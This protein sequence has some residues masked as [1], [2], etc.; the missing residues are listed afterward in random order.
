MPGFQQC[1]E[2]TIANATTPYRI[3]KGALNYRPTDPG[4]RADRRNCIRWVDPLF[5]ADSIH[6]EGHPMTKR[7]TDREFVTHWC[8]CA[9]YAELAK[10]TGMAR[11][12]IQARGARLRKAGVK[13][14]KYSM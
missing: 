1:R 4:P 11:S 13:L 10:L 5:P 7:L 6:Q 3:V 8:H 2:Q 9:S 14:P 12:S